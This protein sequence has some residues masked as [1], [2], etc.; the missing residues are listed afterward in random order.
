MKPEHGDGTQMHP[1]VNRI[2][3]ETIHVSH[4]MLLQTNRQGHEDTILKV[5]YNR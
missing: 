2:Q 1:M 5:S 4:I 3:Q